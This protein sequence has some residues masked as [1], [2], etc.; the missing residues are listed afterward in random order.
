VECYDPSEFGSTLSVEGLDCLESPCPINN[1]AKSNGEMSG[2]YEAMG[3]FVEKWVQ[4]HPSYNLTGRLLQASSDTIPS[5]IICTQPYGAVSFEVSSSHF[6][7]Y[8]KDSIL[9]TNDYF[10]YGLFEKLKTKLVNAGMDISGFIFTFTEQ[11]VYVFM[12][13]S[14]STS[15]TIVKVDESCPAE[16]NIIPLTEENLRLLDITAEENPISAISH[17]LL[18]IPILAYVLSV[19]TAFFIS[20]LEK[21]ELK[22]ERER[23]QMR[24]GRMKLRHDGKV[25]KKEYLSDLY[26]LVKEH[27]D[28]LNK[29]LKEDGSREDLRKLLREKNGLLNALGGE[30][31]RNLTDTKQ[32]LYSLME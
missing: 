24:A 11:G 16:A 22:K 12:D 29:L 7:V 3:I 23:L 26:S 20:Y 17:S 18:T 9:N 13:Y 10:D 28:E 2:S 25:D 6:P 1:I 30:G 19:C 15:L 5:A 4:T 21:I 31:A 27:L 14:E 32:S 8:S